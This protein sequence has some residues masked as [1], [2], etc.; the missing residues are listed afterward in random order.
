MKLIARQPCSFGGKKFYIGDEVPAELVLDAKA[1]EKKHVLAIVEETKI[2]ATILP[3]PDITVA[4]RTKD[5]DMPV[6][7]TG[8]GLQ[9]VFDVLNSTA[10]EAPAI[11]EEMEDG[12][13]LI[14][15]HATDKRKSVKDAAEARA[16][17]LGA[18]EQ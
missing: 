14:L 10:E 6:E 18:G 4:V 15:L 1:Q 9:A 7:L 11:I 8:E 3:K 16:K 5:G 12:D 13:A 2:E 17:A